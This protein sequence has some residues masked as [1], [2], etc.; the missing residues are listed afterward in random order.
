M[1][2]YNDYYII[3]QVLLLMTFIHFNQNRIYNMGVINNNLASHQIGGYGTWFLGNSYCRFC[4]ASP[5]D[6]QRFFKESPF[7]RRIEYLHNRYLLL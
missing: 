5:N 3:L 7:I 1:Y 2:I 6:V 4:L